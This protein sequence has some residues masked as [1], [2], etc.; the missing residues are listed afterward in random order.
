[1]SIW[2][3]EDNS[4]EL[5]SDVGRLKRHCPFCDTFLT[6]LGEKSIPAFVDRETLLIVYVCQTCGWWKMESD[7]Y[8]W[9]G[10]V[11]MLQGNFNYNEWRYAHGTL[12]NL[13]LS[14]FDLPVQEL[15][16][17]LLLKHDA[18]GYVEPRLVEET[19]ADV[20]E[21][22]GFTVIL[23]PQTKD[24][25]IDLILLEGP[26]NVRT[27]VEVK[28]YKNKVGV[29]IIRSF[30]AAL[31]FGD[32]TEGIF[33]ATSGFTKGAKS[34]TEE[35]NRRGLAKVQL[36]DGKWLLDALKITRRPCYASIEEEQAPFAP[37]IRDPERIPKDENYTEDKTSLWY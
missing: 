31:Q 19:V 20:F 29:E 7:F 22:L 3:Y 34:L 37:L 17:Y 6:R 32:L 14:N 16:R 35:A 10:A 4:I 24:G 23:T 27:G 36:L 28:R 11:G 26:D 33:V 5:I 21:N 18:L 1:M 13:S 12:R 2:T 30:V 8:T 25:G 9:T 15:A